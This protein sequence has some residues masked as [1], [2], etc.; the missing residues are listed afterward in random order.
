MGV[1]PKSL[2]SASIYSPKIL[3]MFLGLTC[4]QL[5]SFLPCPN[6]GCKPKAKIT[7]SSI[8]LQMIWNP[9]RL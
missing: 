7:T 9:K 3:G 8:S 6:L 4:Y 1:H 5:I 2:K